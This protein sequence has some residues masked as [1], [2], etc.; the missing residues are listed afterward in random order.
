MLSIEKAKGSP[1]TELKIRTNIRHKII[2]KNMAKMAIIVGVFV[3]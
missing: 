1:I 2:F 3:S